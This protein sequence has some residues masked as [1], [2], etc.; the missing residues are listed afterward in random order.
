MPPGRAAAPTSLAGPAACAASRT[1]F[2]MAIDS[3]RHRSGPAG[4]GQRDRHARDDRQT[5]EARPLPLAEI[6]F[7]VTE[8]F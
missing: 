1:I 7:V 8:G 4:I 5:L 6:G 2:I 3:L